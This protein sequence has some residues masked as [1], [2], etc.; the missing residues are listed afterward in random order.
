VSE[1]GEWAR[2]V[3]GA[4][5]WYH[6]SIKDNEGLISLNSLII[7]YLAFSATYTSISKSARNQQ[8]G[9]NAGKEIRKGEGKE[10]EFLI[11]FQICVSK[12]QREEK[13][14]TFN[15]LTLNSVWTLASTLGGGG[16]AAAAGAGAAA[17]GA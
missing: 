7:L 4:S 9:E 1:E 15:N 6:T 5:T 8:I 17:A 10:I 2:R 12:K 14:I 11:N 13:V 3:S 16:A